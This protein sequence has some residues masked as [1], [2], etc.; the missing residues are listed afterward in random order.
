[1]RGRRVTLRR[2]KR[3]TQGHVQGHVQCSSHRTRYCSRA[4]PHPAN[5]FRQHNFIRFSNISNSVRYLRG[6]RHLVTE[7]PPR[8]HGIREER[9][10]YTVGQRR[11]TASVPV[12]LLSSNIMFDDTSISNALH[13]QAIVLWC[14]CPHD[15]ARLPPISSPCQISYHTIRTIGVYQHCR[16]HFPQRRLPCFCIFYNVPSLTSIF[17]TRCNKPNFRHVKIETKKTENPLSTYSRDS[18]NDKSQNRLVCQ[19]RN[20][21]KKDT[22]KK[23]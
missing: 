8:I 19:Q 4:G 9:S 5:P 12:T 18:R 6:R 10:Q 23:E 15:A 13:F 16:I 14:M 22:S 3:V 2:R 20:Q 11:R 1:M 17:G 21:K 7:R